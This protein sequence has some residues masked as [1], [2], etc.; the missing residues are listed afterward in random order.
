MT[1]ASEA[2][3]LKHLS[4]SADAVIEDTFPWSESTQLDH[5]AVIGAIK[6]LLADQYVTAE[7]LSTSFYSLT[8]EGE[9][10]L[11]NGSQEI[12]VLK[13]LEEAGKLSIPDLQGKVGKDVAKIGMG[14]CMKKKWIKK[15]GGDL[16][17]QKKSDEVED[18][19]KALLQKLVDGKFAL[20]AITDK[21]GKQFL[22]NEFLH[23]IFDIHTFQKR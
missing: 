7:D 21:V 11:A 15:D 4:A 3:I 1:D 10:I 13:A 14:N 19:V 17:P 9:S 8:P 18:E 6:S 22:E 23:V 16:V 20:D 12:V 5:A 2:A